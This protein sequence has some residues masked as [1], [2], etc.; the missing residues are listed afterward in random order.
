MLQLKGNDNL[1]TMLLK[2]ILVPDHKK[3]SDAYE[4]K[5]LNASEGLSHETASRI[6]INKAYKEKIDKAIGASDGDFAESYEESVL[7]PYAR[8]LSKLIINSSES[9]QTFD[10]AYVNSELVKELDFEFNGLYLINLDGKSHFDLLYPKND[11]ICAEIDPLYKENT[12]IKE[13][14]DVENKLEIQELIRIFL[15]KILKKL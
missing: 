10:R 13:E 14:R 7:L 15:V 4:L 8:K 2:A 1:G 9:F 5:I 12:R 11:P 3:I 6:E